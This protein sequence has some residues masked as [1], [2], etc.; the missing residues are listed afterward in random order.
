VIRPARPDDVPAIHALVREL[1][2]YERS[3]DA[4]E[5]SEDDLAALLFSTAPGA[6]CHVAEAA[7]EVVGMAFWYLTASTWTGRQ[8]LWLEDLYVR[9]ADRGHGHGV[10]LLRALAQVCVERG[11]RRLEWWVLDWN[12]PAIEFYRALGAQPMQ[13]W[14]VQRLG[15]EALRR[16]ASG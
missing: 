1:A 8:G 7:G 6:S 16:L 2:A 14:T 11:Y 9:P 13:E 4:V 3:L 10:G 15:D 12:S 5:A